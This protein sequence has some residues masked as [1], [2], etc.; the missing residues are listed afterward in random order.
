MPTDWRLH[1]TKFV[2]RIALDVEVEL[3]APLCLRMPSQPEPGTITLKLL[4]DPHLHTADGR[5]VSLSSRKALALIAYLCQSPGMVASREKI[6]DLLWGNSDGEH[7]RNSLRQTLAVLRRNLADFGVDLLFSDGDRLQLRPSSIHCDVHCFVELCFGPTSDLETAAG[8]YGG[9][10]LDGFFAGSAQFEDWVAEERERLA[11]LASNVL[12]QLARRTDGNAGLAY[13]RNLLSIEPARESSHRLLMELLTARGHHDLALK[14]YQQCRTILQREY[15]VTPDPETERVHKQIIQ[16]RQP[17]A[18]NAPEGLKLA[19]RTRESI[20]ARPS[21]GVQLFVNLGGNRSEDIFAAGLAQEIITELSEQ[22]ELIVRV[23]RRQ[24][25]PDAASPTIAERAAALAVRFILSGSIQKT[26]AGLRVNAQLI[27][28]AAGDHVWAERFEGEDQPEFQTQ[29]AKSIALATHVELLWKKW[30]LRDRAPPDD[31]SA[32]TLITRA[33][34][35]F[36]EMTNESVSAAVALAEQALQIDPGSIRGRRTLSAA[37]SASITLGVLPSTQEN[38]NR[39]L[40]L[41]ETVVRLA[42]DDEIARCELA[43]ALSNMGRHADAADELRHAVNLNPD[44][45]NA[46][47]DL[48]EQ[49]ALL[50]RSAEALEVVN[51]AIRLSSYDP[52]EFW[53]YSTIAMAKFAAGNYGG[54]LETSRELARSKPAFLRGLLFW[55]ASAAA[56]GQLE[57]ARKAVR[58]LLEQV[59]VIRVGNL[60]PDYMPR[61]VQDE[62][63]DRFVEML[64]KAGLP[65]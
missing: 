54:A 47:A 32:R 65:D 6:A 11:G 30:R 28:T 13:A 25:G 8:L 64:R 26:K 35:K 15:G 7:A 58:Q 37:T 36:F 9:Q 40:S 14:Q 42:P 24:H 31:P 23:D 38:L 49:L 10:F 39:A 29:V 63:H 33:I 41:A 62:H 4:G 12:E 53:R 57:E 5:D 34:I 48:A 55:A 16:A 2:L 1:R 27:D 43:W 18:A 56:T 50:G 59:P 21:V 22:K 45:P 52:L 3:L 20:E 17:M 44:S 61:Y 60:A 19:D 46:R 51:A